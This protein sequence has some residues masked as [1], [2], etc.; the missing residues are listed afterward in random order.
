MFQ[1]E[2][3]TGL[4][5]GLKRRGVPP[6]AFPKVDVSSRCSSR[7]S[8]RANSRP[9]S[10]ASSRY[11]YRSSS[12]SQKSRRGTSY[13]SS[14]RRAGSSVTSLDWNIS[15]FDD[16]EADAQSLSRDR[17]GMSYPELPPISHRPGSGASRQSYADSGKERDR[18]RETPRGVI[19]KYEKPALLSLAMPVETVGS[20]AFKRSHYSPGSTGSDNSRDRDQSSSNSNLNESGRYRSKSY[21]EPTSSVAEPPKLETLFERKQ[22]ER[23]SNGTRNDSSPRNGFTNGVNTDRLQKSKAFC[24]TTDTEEGLNT[25]MRTTKSFS[26]L[27]KYHDNQKTVASKKATLKKVNSELNLSQLNSAHLASSHS[28]NPAATTAKPPRKQRHHSTATTPHTRQPPIPHRPLRA[29][30]S[31]P[32]FSQQAEEAAARL[33]KV[34]QPEPGYDSDGDSDSIKERRILDWLVGVEDAERPPSPCIDDDA[35][36]QT[37]TAIH[38]VYEGD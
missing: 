27:T 36:A 26:N 28:F 9:R 8:S 16:D 30:K 22:Y 35:P 23:H 7:P 34:P 18:E 10:R 3:D 5:S 17:P 11:T 13:T 4:I 14:L 15:N 6:E 2:V 32:N 25:N 37:D 12:L 24:V 21:N 1:G 33:R 38:I 19:L 20:M 29:S 31:N